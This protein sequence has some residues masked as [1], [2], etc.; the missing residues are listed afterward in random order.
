MCLDNTD[1][2]R[3]RPC[4]NLRQFSSQPGSFREQRGGFQADRDPLA[5]HF[6]EKRGRYELAL[7]YLF[8]GIKA[9]DPVTVRMHAL[10]RVLGNL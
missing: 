5:V 8:Q 7:P 2:A 9:H 3:L 4:D 10:E 1:A 6:V